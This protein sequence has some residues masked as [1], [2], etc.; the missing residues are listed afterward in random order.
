MNGLGKFGCMLN[1][2]VSIIVVNWNGRAHLGECLNSL[3]NQTFLDFEIIVVDNGSTDGSVEYV[4][5]H[6][7]G[8]ARILRNSENTGFSKGNNQG[9]KVARGEY[10]ALLNNDA[11]ADR[12]W[13]TELVRVA[14]ADCRIGMLASKIYLQGG[15]KIIDNVGHLIYRDGLNRG[16]GR[17]E[18]DRGQFDKIEEVL[19]PSGCAALYRREMLE[20]IGLFDEDFFAYGDDTDLGLRGRLAGWKCLYV[21]QA[22]VSHRY[23][24]SSSPYSPLKAFFVERNRVW[25]AVKYFPLSLLLKSPFYTL[26]R[27]LLQGYGA[28]TGRGAAGRFS[29]EYS[30]WQLLRILVKAYFS[31]IRGLPKMWKK[32]KGMKRLTRVNKEEILSWFNRF[33][34]SAREISL[35]ELAPNLSGGLQFTPSGKGIKGR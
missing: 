21:P 32:R 17:L 16:R 26:W 11:Q 3:H 10:I 8:F 29:Q 13:L 7:A 28:L 35:K 33:G 5:S 4:E 6:F 18:E 24:Q 20:E 12:H 9:I 30:R 1:P 23:S 15:R 25:I 22:V 31:A 14:E 27:F 2:L 19:F 34:I